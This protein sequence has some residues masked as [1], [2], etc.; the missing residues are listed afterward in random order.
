MKIGWFWVTAFGFAPAVLLA[1]L[2]WLQRKLVS[3]VTLSTWMLPA[4]LVLASAAIMLVLANKSKP[5]NQAE[6]TI[7]NGRFVAWNLI[8]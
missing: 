7:T 2:A 5:V 8:V 6:L 1:S 4:A 3:R